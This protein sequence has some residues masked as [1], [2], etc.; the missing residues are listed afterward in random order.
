MN[1]CNKY[2]IDIKRILRYMIWSLVGSLI[3]FAC[4][5]VIDFLFPFDPNIIYST[6]IMDKNGEMVNAFLSTD[7]KWRLYVDQDVITEDFQKALLFKEDQYFYFHPGVNPLAVLRALYQNT[8]FQNRVSGASTITMQLARLLN[9]KPRTYINKIIEAFNALQLEFH[10]S[11]HEIF[12]MYVNLLPYGG[13]IEGIQSAAVLYFGKSPEMLSLAEIAALITIPNRPSSLAI[14]HSK[15]NINK[16]K[17]RWIEKFKDEHY[18][19]D[20][21]LDEAKSEII[22]PIRRSVPKELPHLSIRLKREV[23]KP[24]IFTYIDTE[25]THKIENLV[26]STTEKLIVENIHNATVLVVNNNDLSVVSYIG[27]SD[28]S[29]PRDGGQ[30]DGIQAVRS[31]GS[32]LKPLLY[33]M[34]FDS[35]LITPKRSLFDVSMNF[36]GYEPRNYNEK[37]EGTINAESAL[38]KSLNAPAVQLLH[39]FGLES[40][41]NRLMAAG[42]ETISKQS[43]QL[44]LSTILGGCGATMEELVAL[45]TSFANK[46]NLKP[47]KFSKKEATREDSVQILTP[48]STFILSNILKEVTRPDLPDKWQDSPNTPNVAWKTGTSFGRKDAW[49]IGFDTEYTVGVWLGNFSGEGSEK[50]AGTEIAAPLLLDIF[51]L[52]QRN[53]QVWFQQPKGVDFKWVCNISGQSPNIF[54]DHKV[55]DFYITGKSTYELCSHSKPVLISL[56]SST[57]YCRTCMKYADNVIR[58]WY[59][60]Y[61]AKLISHFHQRDVSFQGIP[62]HYPY[63]ERVYTGQGFEIT[64]PTSNTVYYIDK[65]DTSSLLLEAQCPPNSNRLYWYINDKFY[66]S[67]KIREKLYCSPSKGKVKI[68]C[69][70]DRGRNENIVIQVKRISF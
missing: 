20:D 60:N 29:D 30:V 16:A 35:G 28:F 38:A 64:S 63:C 43:N 46:G 51:S 11:K 36:D 39:D 67:T 48:Q 26:K 2:W 42:F 6:M 61:S 18:F 19:P 22:S 23:K 8:I 66:R 34:A 1:I 54:C 27:S 50:L 53:N 17:N 68:S 44:G 41:I 7:E 12:R 56:D 47:L 55:K 25:L 59:P 62:S 4:F 40:F 33:G 69:S 13:N 58:A 10:F 5:I 37:F 24:V 9:P 3:G 57:S 21:Q 15:K 65:T 31:P 45:Y 32:T 70:D 52:L 49:A 14:S